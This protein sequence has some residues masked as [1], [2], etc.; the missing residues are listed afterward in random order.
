M[1]KFRYRSSTVDL[2][3]KRE[4]SFLNFGKKFCLT[5]SLIMFFSIFIF[6]LKN[7][8]FIATLNGQVQLSLAKRRLFG[9]RKIGAAH[10][11]AHLGILANVTDGLLGRDPPSGL[12]RKVIYLQLFFVHLER[13]AVLITLVILFDIIQPHVQLFGYL[14]GHCLRC[15]SLGERGAAE[16][17]PGQL[18]HIVLSAQSNFFRT[19]LGIF[20]LVGE[21]RLR[22]YVRSSDGCGGRARL[23]HIDGG[24]LRRHLQLV[25]SGPLALEQVLDL[26]VEGNVGVLLVRVDVQSERHLLQL[27]PLVRERLLLFVELEAFAFEAAGAGAHLF[28]GRLHLGR[29]L[30]PHLPQLVGHGGARHLQ[31]LDHVTGVA[32]LLRIQKSVR[33]TMV[34]GATGP[35]APV[36]IVLVVV[37]T[38]V[39]DDQNEVLDVEAARRD[40]RGDQ[41]RHAGLL[42]KVHDALAVVLVDAA[43]QRHTRVGV[44]EQIFAQVVGVLL[45]VDEHDHAA[46]GLKETEQLE[47]LEILFVL[48][49]DDHVLLD[50][51]ADDAA[52]AHRHLDRL[53][54][55]LARQVLHFFGKGG[56]EHDRLPVGPH[57]LQYFVDLGL[58]AH[59]EHAVRLVQDHVGDPSQVGDASVVGGEHVDHAARRAHNDLGAALQ[60]GYLL[61]Y[62]RA[63]VHSDHVEAE[64]ARK[65]ATLLGYLHGE[66]AG[67]RHHH[68]YGAVVDLEWRLI[69]HVSEH[70]QQEGK[71]FAA[72]RFGYADHVAA[73][74]DYGHRL[75]LDGRRLVKAV[76]FQALGHFEAHAALGP[77]FDRLGAIFSLN[78]NTLQFFSVLFDLVIGGHHLGLCLVLGVQTLA[79]KVVDAVRVLLLR[80][81]LES[82]NVLFHNQTFIFLAFAGRLGN[83]DHNGHFFARL[84]VHLLLDCARRERF[85]VY[86]FHE[87][88]QRVLFVLDDHI[89]RLRLIFLVV[90]VLQVPRARLFA[91]LALRGRTVSGHSDQRH[92]C[93]LGRRFLGPFLVAPLFDALPT[94][95]HLFFESL[96]F[97]FFFGR[98]FGVRLA[99]ELGLVSKALGVHY[100]RVDVLSGGYGGRPSRQHLSG[101]RA[102][103]NQVGRQRL[104][105]RPV[106]VA[107]FAQL[108]LGRRRLY[109]LVYVVDVDADFGRDFANHFGECGVRR[110]VR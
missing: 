91:R 67:R 41:Q 31:R 90:F 29:V 10:S 24:R 18:V 16:Y 110:F 49:D 61:G 102:Y 97:G 59:V 55:G 44:F 58:E 22:H 85:G 40:R 53:V 33:V 92:G 17:G 69:E 79:G 47:Q 56:A 37:G 105:G 46:L 42:E 9:G 93:A 32:L 109:D 52:A 73:R 74:H 2:G 26:L 3:L 4:K 81:V 38:V 75:G 107:Y 71:R 96:L 39:V 95:P 7:A 66:L 15:D 86:V 98:Y 28:A 104:L 65:L 51:F 87:R 63:A 12:L 94:L 99:L 62:A 64:V 1:S 34:T 60:L 6:S 8:L 27:F 80:V 108:L 77:H 48:V 50:L 20:E 83:A 25:L 13:V 11:D 45:L 82:V 36:H 21:A 100:L 84:L 101:A 35:A 78:L 68:G 70:G 54:Q 19:S 103:R 106:L 14:L 89:R 5:E 88:V 30:V 76:S 23:R 72:A 43:V 57:V